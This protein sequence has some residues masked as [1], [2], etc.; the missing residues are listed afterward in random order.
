M[1]RF[2]FNV[3]DG[4]E[5]PDFDGIE[6][7]SISDARRQATLYA[8]ELLRSDPASFW[9]GEE[10]KMEV[11]DDRGLVLFHLIFVGIDAPAAR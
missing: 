7:P 6:L 3:H 2:F 10:W 1:P 5:Y 8:G 4:R 9:S 11:T